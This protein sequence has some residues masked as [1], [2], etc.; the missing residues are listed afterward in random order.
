MSLS[1]CFEKK[2]RLLWESGKGVWWVVNE[3]I[4][5]GENAFSRC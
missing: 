2:E 1:A 5:G 3:A 4:E